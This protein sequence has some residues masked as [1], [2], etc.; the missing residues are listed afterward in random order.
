MPN[1][2]ARDGAGVIFPS[3]TSRAPS[4]SSKRVAAACHSI[5]S[6]QMVPAPMSSQR[7]SNLSTALPAM[8]EVREKKAANPSDASRPYWAWSKPR[9]T[10][11]KSR[12]ASARAFASS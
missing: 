7:E 12:D 2:V 6:D 10:F 11:M 8:S 5:A 4:T 9:S 1:T 3:A